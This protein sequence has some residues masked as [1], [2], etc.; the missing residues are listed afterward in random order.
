MQTNAR[1]V[2]VGRN[3]GC[4]FA[5]LMLVVSWGQ[6][7]LADTIA[8]AV[9]GSVFDA[10]PFDG[11]GDGLSDIPFISNAAA[12][13]HR[14]VFEFDL[15][16]VPSG[17]VQSAS[18]SGLVAANN[19]FDTGLRVHN[20]D[21]F[22][23]DGAITLADF[24]AAAA[25]AGMFS[26]PSGSSTMFDFDVAASLQTLLDGGATHFAVR[27]SA[28]AD[29]QFSDVVIDE[30]DTPLRLEFSV[31]APLLGDYDGGGSV[32]PEDYTLW[33]DTFGATS[34]DL[35][36]DGN[37]DV[38]VNAPDYTVWRDHLPDVGSG[39]ASATALPEPATLTM[40]T[41]ALGALSRKNAGLVSLAP[42]SR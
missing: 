37:Q 26:H 33:K 36:A 12:N 24:D 7:V 30:P 25:P 3:R 16:G 34:G 32:G 14:A 15:S 10:A 9:I 31:A 41:L 4:R 35:R 8:P 6:H 23:G 13:R 40:L 38:V 18:L 1:I 42:A 17:T 27:I 11:V 5:I 29:P 21:V 39:D 28:G 19:S 22:A 2:V 20:V